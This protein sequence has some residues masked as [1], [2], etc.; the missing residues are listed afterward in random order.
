MDIDKIHRL[1]SAT[2]FLLPLIPLDKDIFDFVLPYKGKGSRLLNAYIY[3]VDVPK[4]QKDHISVVHSNYQDIGFNAFEQVLE[5]NK[6]YVDSYDIANTQYSVK[7]FEI[8]K[9]SLLSYEAFLRG[10]YSR[11][12]LHDMASV[13]HFDYL[14]QGEYLQKVFSKSDDL[15][16]KKEEL[17]G[18]SLKDKE[19][20][21][22][23][24][25]EY[26]LLHKNLKDRISSSKLNINEN[27]LNEP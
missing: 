1:N 10:E 2:I 27:F 22:I 13:L 4:Y 20:W 25:P 12:C 23:Y 6:Y 9:G 5:N 3:D 26:D 24:D 7:V 15:R 19:L 17:L 14:N 21:S 8:P 16:I 11:F 18:T